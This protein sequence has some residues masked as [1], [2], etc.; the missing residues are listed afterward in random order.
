MNNNSNVV[1]DAPGAEAEEMNVKNISKWLSKDLDS[2]VVLLSAIR[3]DTE[4]REYMARWFHGRMMNA[5]HQ[6]AMRQNGGVDGK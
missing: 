5:K 2:M 1:A 6:E 4:L 3:G